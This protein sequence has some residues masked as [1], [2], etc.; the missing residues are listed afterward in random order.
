MLRIGIQKAPLQKFYE[1][2]IAC[3]TYTVEYA[4]AK[5]HFDWLEISMLYGKK[6]KHATIYDGY[7]AEAA[8]TSI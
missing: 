4:A 6:N 2:S 5:K 8:S 7:N 3:K 1:L